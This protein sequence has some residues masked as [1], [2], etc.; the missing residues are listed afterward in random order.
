MSAQVFELHSVAEMEDLGRKIGAHLR[1]GDVLL[2]KGDLGAGKT[3][4]TRGLG[5]S[6]G[7]TGITSPTFVIS[8]IYQATIPLI[9]V[10]AYRLV[11]NE[12]ALFDDLDLES[13]I[14]NSITVIEWG[15]GFVERLVGEYISVEIEFGADEN[16]R[17]VTV[18]GLRL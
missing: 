4:F 1:P 8:K 10:D 11:G 3:T 12:L 16:D 2:L 13:R 14:P 6:L 5:D 15:S 17:L 18:T 7:I 9:H